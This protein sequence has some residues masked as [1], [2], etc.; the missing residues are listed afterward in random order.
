MR[1]PIR[2]G[3]LGMLAVGLGIGAA[4][5][6]TPGV[7]SADSSTDPFS[8]IDELLGSLSLPAQSTADLD[9]QVSI[10]GMDLFPTAGN[11]ATATSDF[12]NIAIAIGDGAN[13]DAAAGFGDV[14]FA[15]GTNSSASAGLAGIFDLAF[16]DG[17]NST[18]GAGLG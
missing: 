2:I 1:H 13:A 12:G 17:T 16:A 14:A 8:S 11:T 18:A 7:A 6:S 4:L 15:D 5:G 10:F 3:R 9:M